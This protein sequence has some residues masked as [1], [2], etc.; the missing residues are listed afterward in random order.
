MSFIVI[1]T[2]RGREYRGRYYPP[3]WGTRDHP[4][5]PE[6]LSIEELP[7]LDPDRHPTIYAH[8]IKQVRAGR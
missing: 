5:D 6:E 2:L 4:G 8:L 1:I 7:E 3:T